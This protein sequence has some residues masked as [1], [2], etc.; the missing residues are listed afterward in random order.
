MAVQRNELEL[1]RCPHCAVARPRLTIHWHTNTTDHSGSNHRN[2]VIYQC[3]SCGGLVTTAAKGQA[4][5]IVH[6]MFPEPTAVNELIPER[7]RNYL[8]QAIE[9]LHAPSGAIMLAASA[10]DAM[11]KHH[12][13]KEGRLNPRINRAATDHLITTEMAA[14]AHDVRLDA[15]DERHADQ[16]AALPQEVDAQRAID[17]VLALG[18]ILFVLPERVRRG[19][20]AN[21]SNSPAAAQV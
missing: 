2:W 15:N 3:A 20:E 18:E 19:R 5:N 4:M 1:P 17:F 7:A 9:S 10:V 13:Y 16:D 6:E 12:G 21:K 14:W 8:K 11:L